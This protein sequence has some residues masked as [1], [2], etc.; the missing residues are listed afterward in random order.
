VV[1]S[2]APS[3]SGVSGFLSPASGAHSTERCALLLASRTALAHQ[4]RCLG[5]TAKRPLHLLS[6]FGGLSSCFR[7]GLPPTAPLAALLQDQYKASDNRM[8]EKSFS[9]NPRCLCGN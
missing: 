2:R 9:E 4:G 7:W 8:Q 6:L 1:E 3:C 5:G